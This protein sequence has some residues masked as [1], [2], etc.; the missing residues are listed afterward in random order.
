MVPGESIYGMGSSLQGIAQTDQGADGALSS[1]QP[2]S[3]SGWRGWVAVWRCTPGDHASLS[4]DP[5]AYYTVQSSGIGLAEFGNASS[6]CSPA[7]GV[8]GS[9]C[10]PNA[11]ALNP[12][13]LDAFIGTDVPPDAA[14]LASAAAAAGAGVQEVTI[15]V[16]QAPWC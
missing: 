6:N 8:L 2:C 14:M 15:P 1:G 16:A 7:A 5:T 10:D 11:G 9:L 13:V 4:N 12:D 3:A